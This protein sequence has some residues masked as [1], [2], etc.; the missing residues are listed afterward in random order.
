MKIRL[1]VLIILFLVLFL[2]YIFTINYNN[3]RE[4][5]TLEENQKYARI[6]RYLL[7]ALSGIILFGV[8]CAL[9][10]AGL[11]MGVSSP[12]GHRFS[13]MYYMGNN[14]IKY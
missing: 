9:I 1:G 7:F 5:L 2:V 6:V 11:S 13:D 3:K 10:N 12:P 8:V 14:G 4:Y